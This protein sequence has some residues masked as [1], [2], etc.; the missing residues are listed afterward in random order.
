V[1][2][3]TADARMGYDG[4]ENPFLW[5]SAAWYACQ[6]GA[7]LHGTGR[8]VPADVRMG[9]GSIVHVGDSSYRFNHAKDGT[10]HWERIK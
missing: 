2:S 4:N 7:W 3:L 9:R 8:P 1:N 6:L 5:S 10:G